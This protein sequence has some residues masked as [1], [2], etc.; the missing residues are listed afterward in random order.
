MRQQRRDRRVPRAR[1]EGRERRREH[2]QRRRD[3][4][5]RH[6]PRRR[7]TRSTATST[8]HQRRSRERDEHERRRARAVRAAGPEGSMQFTTVNGNVVVEFAGDL[9]ADVDMQTVN[10]SLNTNFE[11]TLIG[12][13][14]PKHLRTHVGRPGGPT[15]P[16]G[17]RQRERGYCGD[18]DLRHAGGVTFPVPGLVVLDDVTGGLR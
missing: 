14:D 16:P 10:G 9:G 3:R 1:A 2:D 4:R 11:M 18:G 8:C 12:R 13:L 5:R 7:R 6:R 17:D 15:N